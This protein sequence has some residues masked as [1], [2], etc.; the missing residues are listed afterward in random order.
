MS[1]RFVDSAAS[2]MD[3]QVVGEEGC[4]AYHKGWLSHQDSVTL[5]T[6]AQGV[7]CPQLLSNIRWRDWDILGMTSARLASSAPWE[8]AFH[9][10]AL[11]G[12]TPLLVVSTARTNASH[13]RQDTTVVSLDYPKSWRLVSAMQDTSALEEA[14]SLHPLMGLMDTDVLRASTV[15]QGPTMNYLVPPQILWGGA[16]FPGPGGRRVISVRQ[17]LHHLS[18]ATVATTN[19]PWAQTPAFHVHQASTAHILALRHPSPAQPM[20]TAKLAFTAW[21]VVENPFHAPLTS[22]HLPLEPRKK[23]TVD[24]VPKDSCAK[25]VTLPLKTTHAPLVTGVQVHSMSFS[26][27]LITGHANVFAIPCQP[28]SECPEGAVDMVPCRAG[29]YCG[30]RTGI[31][32]L[33]P[34]GFACPAGSFTYAGPGQRCVFP[35]YC[36]QGSAHP[37]VCPGGSEALNKSG[38][39]VSAE[40]SCRL[41]VAGTYRSPLL[42]TLTCQP[43]PPGFLCPQ[44]SESYDNQPCPVGHYCPKGTS[45]PRPCP[46]GT[47]GGKSQ[48]AAVEECQPCPPGTFSAL[49]GQGACLPCGSVAFSPPGAS[50]CTCQGLNKIFQKSDG[51]CV[52]QAGHVSYD[53]R[54]LETDQESNSHS[55]E[56][57]QPQVAQHCPPGDVRLAATRECVSP[58]QYDCTSFC[59][60]GGGKLSTT[61]GICQCSGYVSAEEL[62]D[63][64]CLANA[65]QLSLSWD[66]AK[67][68][69]L[70]VE[71]ETEDSIQKELLET[72]GPDLQLPGSARVHLVQFGPHGTF[73]FIISRVDMLISL[74]QGTVTSRPWPQ[75]HH[76][77]TGPKHPNI[78]PQIPNPV[79]CLAA[80]DVL[81]FLLHLLPHNRS[82]S[83]Y[84][85]YQRQ[86]LLN[87]N[88]HWDSGAFRRLSHLVRE[89]NLSLSR[90]AH[91]FLDPGT[92]VF[93][94]NGKPENI[95]VVLVKEEGAAC[96]TGLS[97]VQPSSPYQLGRLGVLR[98]RMLTLGPDW[99]VITG[100]LLSA[101]LAT[102]L[103][104]GL[105]LLLKPA[106]PQACLAKSWKSQWRSVRQPPT[107]TEHVSL[108]DK[109]LSYE[110]LGPWGSRQEADSKE[111]DITQDAG[112]QG[113]LADWGELPRAL[114]LEDFSVR[115][116]YDK[117]EDQS[118]HIAAQLSGH[119]TDALAFYRAASQQLQGLQEF[120]QGVSLAKPPSPVR[121]KHL[122][123]GVKT[124]VETVTAESEES[125]EARACCSAASQTESW[126]FAPGCTPSISPLG[127]QPELN[128]AITT[129]ASVLSQVREPPVGASRKASGQHSEQSCFTS[130]KDSPMLGWPPFHEQEPQS[131][132]AQ[133]APEPL[134]IPKQDMKGRDAQTP[135]SDKWILEAGLRHRPEVELQR[136]IWQVEE[137]LD[138][139]NEEFF[140]LS[141]QTLE[142]QKEDDKADRL[143]LG[144]DNTSVVS[145]AGEYFSSFSV[146]KG[147][148][149]DQGPLHS[150][151][152]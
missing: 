63:I 92:Y 57:C 69:I 148:W 42:D 44:G 70:N 136:K 150:D 133:Q 86:H 65:P 130:R 112:S 149:W 59:G 128:K 83:H 141:A 30:P 74:L 127:F 58:Q 87:S 8:Q 12:S 17:E 129:L 123:S 100:V 21:R 131:R 113:L 33:C 120:L 3:T 144:E 9:F 75:R 1:S 66:P 103:L 107:F 67:E 64:R 34:G 38:L 137:A 119:R 23:K 96:G 117:L 24:P 54:G 40:T 134:Q 93:Q 25:Q 101:S 60:P 45:K 132:R 6:I 26:A 18:C 53:H 15:L 151:G 77:T 72:L 11:L 36:P 82:A 114:T 37:L 121:D 98:H 106:V 115:T 56:D 20:L 90:F 118:L 139:L 48:A 5:V 122:E 109:P 14:L 16:Q 22:R 43:C 95:A 62:C 116:L 147:N 50:T 143:S 138:E 79:I 71:S 7:L 46:A 135:S 32:P 152:L 89:T 47:F 41:C 85:M 111:M 28:G 104:T 55:D 49:P 73:G 91:Q 88:S 146:Y 110:D 145:Q 105:G 29:S 61:L 142:V 102:V 99:A 140:W 10:H 108:R 52:C 76:R 124:C 84:P 125:Q 27:H 2:T 78:D 94:D 39:R 126:Q 51:S 13:A 80:G 97:P 81:L 35:Y 19:P 31:P 68:L 4:S